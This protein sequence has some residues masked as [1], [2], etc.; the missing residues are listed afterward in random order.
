VST[1]LPHVTAADV[2][3]RLSWNAVADAI[4]AAHHRPRPGIADAFV[5]RGDDVLLSRAAWIDGMGAGAK[6]VT[7]IAGN[8][9]RGLP[10]IHGAMLVFDDETG[11]PRA[12]IDSDLITRWKTAGDSVLGARLLA[13]PDAR[14]L[15]IIGAGAVADSLIEAY[16]ELFPGLE[17]IAIASRR[18]ES[19]RALVN[20]KKAMYPVEIAKDIQQT[21]READIIATATTSREPVLRGE[22]VGPGT[23]VDLIGAFTPEMREADDALLKKARIFIDSHATVP[24]HIGELKI[25]LDQ[26]VIARSDILGDLYDLAAG[27]PGRVSPSDI[28]L[29]KNGGGAHL[30]LMTADLI[31]SLL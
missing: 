16:A 12:V 18:A 3:H 15:V 6:T 31:L 29:F 11:R 17:R 28:T 26:G 9:A 23:H 2:A 20:E 4:W 24:D 25:P 8:A 21:V 14:H 5:H 7:A 10:T 1:G 13:R 22:W 19:A 30:D 27:T